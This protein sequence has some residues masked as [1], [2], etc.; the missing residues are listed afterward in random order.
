MDKLTCNSTEKVTSLQQDV[1][2]NET[3]NLLS[4][5]LESWIK[6]QSTEDV[7][8]LITSLVENQLIVAEKQQNIVSI[9]D[10]RLWLGARFTPDAALLFKKNTSWFDV[11]KL[12]DD[13]RNED[14]LMLTIDEQWNITKQKFW[15]KTIKFDTNKIQ[16]TEKL[17][18]VLNNKKQENSKLIDESKLQLCKLDDEVLPVKTPT[19]NLSK[20]NI[21]VIPEAVPMLA[22]DD[23]WIMRISDNG[24]VDNIDQQVE[25][26]PIVEAKTNINE[27]VTTNKNIQKIYHIDSDINDIDVKPEVTTV[28]PE[29]IESNVVQLE[30]HQLEKL[31]KKIKWL[32]KTDANDGN[33]S[34]VTEKSL[35][36]DEDLTPAKE[37][38]EVISYKEYSI[39]SW[40]NLWKIMRSQYG[41]SNPTDIANTLNTLK[42]DPNFGITDINK[43]LRIK[44]KIKLPSKVEVKSPS[45]GDK[46]MEL[47]K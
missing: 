22:I 33:N 1:E 40:D 43:P 45:R 10:E 27:N 23:E 41:L 7:N 13:A 39:K 36:E 32:E 29:I 2:K 14:I 21:Q 42:R 37:K 8:L 26:T 15:N 11:I 38:V 24:D 30:N 20:V 6:L 34:I 47:K 28:A 4:Q 16:S 46:I 19:E 9:L 44:Q 31:D 3:K 35:I 5:Y 18:W 12:S 25:I 17:I